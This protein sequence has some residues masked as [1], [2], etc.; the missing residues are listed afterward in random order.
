MHAIY[1]LSTCCRYVSQSYSVL[2]K[3]RTTNIAENKD[4]IGPTQHAIPWII[5]MFKSP[6]H[7]YICDNG[8]YQHLSY[9]DWTNNTFYY[10]TRNTFCET[11]CPIAMLYSLAA[12]FQRL[13]LLWAC[14]QFCLRIK[15]VG[16]HDNRGLQGRNLHDTIA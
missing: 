3:S 14:S 4:N 13:T 8:L 12:A 1:K 9:L 6:R 10:Q 5:D 16:C 15:T 11:I 2:V 7:M